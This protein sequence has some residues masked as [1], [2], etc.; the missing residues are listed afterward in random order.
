[1]LMPCKDD[2]PER[3]EIL[4]FRTGSD[5]H[6]LLNFLYFIIKVCTIQVKLLTELVI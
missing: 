2:N 5:T 1:M 6:A 4:P 3:P